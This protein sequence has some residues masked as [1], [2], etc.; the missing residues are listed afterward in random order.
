MKRVTRMAAA[1]CVAGL[2]AACASD[3]PV[4][5]VYVPVVSG[6]TASPMLLSR[7]V[8]AALSDGS[9]YTLAEGSW[10]RRVGALVQGDVF[11][12]LG[13]PVVLAKRGGAQ[14]YLV[15]SAGRLV[16]FYLPAGSLFMPVSKPVALP[17]SQRQ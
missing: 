3:A 2:L 11:R 17:F 10:W 14:A 6:E 15:A 9:A 8:V 5:A 7:D 4:R 1:V 16:G 13:Q 12:P